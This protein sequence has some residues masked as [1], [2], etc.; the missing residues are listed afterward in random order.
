MQ[1]VIHG[2][3]RNV[4]YKPGVGR[5]VVCPMVLVA[6]LEQRPRMLFFLE[7]RFR[8]AVK[9]LDSQSKGWCVRTRGRLVLMNA[10]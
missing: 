1:F 2:Q 8:N 3:A 9:R 5:R 7:C 4:V 10:S 6:V